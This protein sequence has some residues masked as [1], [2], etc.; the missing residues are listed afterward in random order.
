MTR[1]LGVQL[2]APEPGLKSEQFQVYQH[3]NF[4]EVSVIGILL[5]IFK[6]PSGYATHLL[7]SIKRFKHSHDTA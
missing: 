7:S 4:N 1:T 3:F 2:L 5:L 6:C